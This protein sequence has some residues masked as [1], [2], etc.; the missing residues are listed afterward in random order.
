MSFG[1]TLPF[2]VAATLLLASGAVAA[3]GTSKSGKPLTAQ[4]E[5]M[6]SCSIDAKSQGLKGTER[7]SFMSTCLKGGAAV[8]ATKVASAPSAARA[9]Q[10]E[11]MKSCNA[12]ARSQGLKGT[13]R[14]SFMSTCLRGEGAAAR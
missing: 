2:V 11:R 12:D 7:K 9:A 6:K 1:K 10:Q 3:Q 5:K 4:Q 13:E 14:K 8:P